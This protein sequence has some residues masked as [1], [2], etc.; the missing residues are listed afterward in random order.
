MPAC[1]NC[2]STQVDEDGAHG[3]TICMGCGNVLEDQIIVSETQFSEGG[4]GR[5]HMMGALVTDDGSVIGGSALP[6]RFG[7]HQNYQ[8]K[9]VED[10]TRVMVCIANRL[11]LAQQHIDSAV[12][13]YKMALSKRMLQ[14]KRKSQ[15]CAACLYIVCRTEHTPH[16]LLDFS[17]II[18]ENMFQLLRVYTKLCSALCIK[19]PAADPCLFISRY[20]QRLQLG[21]KSDVICVTAMRLVSRMKRDWMATGRRPSSLCGA[22]L[23]VACRLHG[24][25]RQIGDIAKIVRNASATISKRLKEFSQTPSSKLSIE[26]FENVDLGEEEDPPA[27]KALKIRNKTKEAELIEVEE[28]VTQYKRQLEEELTDETADSSNLYRS[29]DY[30]PDSHDGDGGEHVALKTAYGKIPNYIA[31]EAPAPA[32]DPRVKTEASI[33]IEQALEAEDEEIFSDVDDNEIDTLI[34]TPQEIEL[35]KKI[36]AATDL[37]EFLAEKEKKRRERAEE[38]R[39]RP[40]RKYKRSQRSINAGKAGASKT[41]AEAMEKMIKEKKL[42]SKINYEVLKKLGS[43]CDATIARIRR[44]TARDEEDEPS[45]KR[46]RLSSVKSEVSTTSRARYDTAT[47][48]VTDDDFAG[49]EDDYLNYS[50]D[51][52]ITDAMHS[53]PYDED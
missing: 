53:Y 14:G 43:E 44:D 48:Q 26:E 6:S 38:E 52:A 42:S 34:L 21:D 41:P 11:K 10:A 2:G 18:H 16:I 47:S 3:Y 35:K 22:A 50:E 32:L 39:A 31:G 17:E 23:V 51:L 20:A 13:F 5:K 7:A 28:E 45:S 15:V 36:W 4:S 8:R 24:A 19:L 27:Y 33:K 49:D 37:D 40:K 12:M 25:S 30:N 1:K 9:I 46:Q 29:P